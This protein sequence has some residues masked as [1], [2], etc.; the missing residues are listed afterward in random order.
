MNPRDTSQ[1]CSSCGQVRKM[2][3]RCSLPWGA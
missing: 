2:A 3:L 1:G